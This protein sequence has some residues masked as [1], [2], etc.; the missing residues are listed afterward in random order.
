MIW[1]LIWAYVVQF[2]HILLTHESL[3]LLMTCPLPQVHFVLILLALSVVMCV[4][5]PHITPLILLGLV[6][7]GFQA[8][9]Q[10]TLQSIL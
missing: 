8:T 1:C 9:C 4:I 6:A 7:Y 3:A 2:G 10:A 5:V